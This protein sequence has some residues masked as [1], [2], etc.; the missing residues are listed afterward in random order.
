[1][2][3]GQSAGGLGAAGMPA[4]GLVLAGRTRTEGGLPGRTASVC[5]QEW[6]RVRHAERQVPSRSSGFRRGRSIRGSDWIH[7]R[8]VSR[9][10]VVTGS[11]LYSM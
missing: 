4:G 10:T 5:Q 2:G 1:M 11:E 7:R 6:S 9:K 3:V 8:A